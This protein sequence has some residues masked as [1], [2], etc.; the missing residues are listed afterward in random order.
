MADSIKFTIG[1]KLG[2]SYKGA[3]SQAVA[4]ARLANNSVQKEMAISSGIAVDMSKLGQF[5]QWRKE[6]LASMAEEARLQEALRTGG[7]RGV[8]ASTDAAYDAALI[9]QNGLI[10]VRVAQIA[11]ER[12]A[13]VQNDV[14]AK[15]AF[16]RLQIFKLEKAA[17]TKAAAEAAAAQFAEMEAANL[18]V[19]RGYG[20]AYPV[21]PNDNEDGRASNRRIEYHVAQ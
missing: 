4:E 3:L 17:E 2:T 10:K 19:A 20:E 9:R 1:G 16:E 21:A 18:L 11:A 5:K 14:E 7:T 6:Y 12:A 15:A 8:P 13:K